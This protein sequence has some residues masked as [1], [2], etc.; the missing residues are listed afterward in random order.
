MKKKTLVLA[1]AA[2]VAGASF[3]PAEAAKKKK[4]EVKPEAVQAPAPV[5]LTTSSDTLS[6]VAGMMLTDGL[7]SYLQ[8]QLNVDTACIADF[9]AGFNEAVDESSDPHEKARRAGQQIADQIKQGMLPRMKQD[10]TNTPDSIVEQTL[11]RGFADAM[12]GDTA[13]FHADQ[14]INLFR[15]KQQQNQQARAQIMAQ[16]GRDFL[17]ANASKEGVITTPSG[18]QYKILV[19][20]EG[21]VPQASDKVKVHYEGRLIDGTVFDASSKHGNEPVTFRAD[22]VIRGWTEALTM[23][24]VGSKWQLFIPQELAYGERQAGNIPPYSA[25]IFDV[26]LVAI[27]K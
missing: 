22:Q 5:V 10:F 16:P 1:L 15:L 4:K 9:V 24:P 13:V 17:N 7:M 3:C 11:F 8:Q 2:L 18:L 6:Y 23:M 12:M 19:K 25:L 26:E 20:G 14:A 27:E 21:Q